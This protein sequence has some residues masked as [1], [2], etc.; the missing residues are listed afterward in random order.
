MTRTLVAGVAR[1]SINPPL[2]T[3]QTGFRLFGNPVQAI[4]S[5]L[6]ATALVLGNGAT[7][8]VV[9]GI[10]LSLVGIDL[11][12]RAE[13]PAQEMRVEIAQALGVPVAHVL[14]NTS[15]THAGVALPDYM[16]DTPEQM[17]LKERYRRFLVRALVEAAMEADA[18]L[19]P[20]RIGCGWGESTIGVYRRETRDGR[21]V[22]GEVPGHPI[23]PSVGVIR[24]DDLG[25]SPIATVFRY[26]CHP[27]TMGPRSAVA[28]SDY[29]GAARQVVERSLG[30]LALFLQGCGGNVNPRA[31]MGLEIDCR[32]TKNRVG[33]EL[34]GEV[35]KVA[36]GI[37]TDRRAGERRPLG[38]IPNILF[39][40]WEPVDGDTCTHLAAAESTIALDYVDLPSPA[41]SEAILAARR[42]TLAQLRHADALEWEVRVA[43][44]QEDWAEL[45]VEATEREHPTCDLFLQAIRVNDIVIAG[46]NAELFFET[47]LEIRA[48]SPF[49]DTFALGYTNGTVGYIPR[50]EDYPPGGWDVHAAYAVPDLIFQVH[51]HPVALRPDSERRA[52][53]GALD[54]IR[55]LRRLPPLDISTS[56]PDSTI[57]S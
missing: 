31:G 34:G 10:D 6:T 5:D 50:A 9:I 52:V 14:L 51:P 36:A 28:S 13:R 37:R 55:Q 17:A 19:Q 22:L 12:L 33:M 4:E 43:E 15:H 29:P 45:L 47:G 26:S 8:V 3:R 42:R 25:G 32:D 16:P 7:R 56:I 46:V 1:R 30:G 40:P 44:K 18:G 2:G 49:T 21:D 24:V 11:S 39:T 48:R 35:V 20:A 38:N 27:V 41:E 53:R 54:L 57:D 23:D